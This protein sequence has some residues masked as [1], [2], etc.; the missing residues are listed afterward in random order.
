[1]NPDVQVPQM[2]LRVKVAELCG[3]TPAS[4]SRRWWLP[5]SFWNWIEGS[6]R[7]DGLPDFLNDLNAC[8]EFEK[9][10]LAKSDGVPRPDLWDK[11]IQYLGGDWPSSM[12]THATAEQRCL[13]F[14][15]TMEP[16]SDPTATDNQ[17][18]SQDI[19]KSSS[20]VERGSVT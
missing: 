3:W 17:P 10:I 12:V 1:M 6:R 8:H 13:A 18:A 5:P 16:P 9:I 2:E 4:E 15:K 20:A 14:V 11:Y 7:Q 19:P